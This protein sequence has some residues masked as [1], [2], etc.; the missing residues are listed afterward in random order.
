MIGHEGEEIERTREDELIIEL[1]DEQNL[2]K[3]LA[4]IEA[5]TTLF[6]GDHQNRERHA[7]DEALFN[8]GVDGA[9]DITVLVVL[10]EHVEEVGEARGSDEALSVRS[11]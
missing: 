6:Y 2:F 9:D 3:D 5:V 11:S 8:D 7:V 4:L 10:G 1:E